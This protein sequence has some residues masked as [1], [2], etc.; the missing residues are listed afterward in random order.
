MMLFVLE[1]IFPPF[2][3]NTKVSIKLKEEEN[4]LYQTKSG[5]QTHRPPPTAASP[6]QVKAFFKYFLLSVL[7]TGS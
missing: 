2:N 6:C 4:F 3:I 1:E 7:K 5:P